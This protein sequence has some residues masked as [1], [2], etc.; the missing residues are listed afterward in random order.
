MNSRLEW[1]QER[2]KGIGGSDA[3]IVVM[4]EYYGKTV[5]DLFYEKI[6]P[7]ID[8]EPNADMRRG[9][10]QE[11]IAAQLFED[12]SGLKVRRVNKILT[13]PKHKFMLANIDRE[14]LNQDSILEIKCP[15]Y[16]TFSKW[17]REGIPEGPIIQ[18][19]H[20]LAIKGKG[21]VIYG[22][23]CAEIDELMIVPINVMIAWLKC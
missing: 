3:P 11:P 16:M 15:R 20:Y 22:I 4:G 14:I 13:H 2:Q 10:R 18:G 6:N 19:Q 1:L 7:I 5:Q 23:F 9:I 21:K 8:S 12:Q 17:K